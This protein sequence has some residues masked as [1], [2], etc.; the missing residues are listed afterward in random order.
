[1]YSLYDDTGTS[2]ESG[3]IPTHDSKV[4]YFRSFDDLPMSDDENRKW[5]PVPPGSE[6]NI[7]NP[8]SG[9]ALENLFDPSGSAQ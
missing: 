2:P 3:L 1:M 9:S 4:N 6:S 5:L 8:V 7:D